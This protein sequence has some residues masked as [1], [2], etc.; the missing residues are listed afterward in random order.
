MTSSVHIREHYPD[1]L[2]GFLEWQTDPIYSKHL[3]WLPQS[4]EDAISNFGEAMRQQN[5]KNRSEY[6]FAVIHSE[7]NQYVGDVGFS[8]TEKWYGNCGWF[9]RNSQQGKGYATEAVMQLIHFAFESLHLKFLTASCRKANIP[10]YR[11]MQKCNFIKQKETD[12][13]IWFFQ[14]SKNWSP[15]NFLTNR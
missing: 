4:R 10:S 13:R 11:I 9:I 2:E 5:I 12:R 7:L 1:D 15:T 6:F 3:S 8:L 14:S